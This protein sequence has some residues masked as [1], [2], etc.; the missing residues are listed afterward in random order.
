[1]NDQINSEQYWESRFATQDW[2]QNC[3]QQQTNYF[4]EQFLEN[5]PTSVFDIMKVQASLCDWGCAE[6]QATYAIKN[7]FPNLNVTGIDIS[8]SAIHTAKNLYDNCAF[9]AIDLFNTKKGYDV[10]FTSN[11]LE[12]FENPF[13]VI[14]KLLKHTKKMLIILVPFQEYDR[15]DEH[16]YTFDYKNVPQQI[17]NFQLGCYKTFDCKAVN[18][19]Y[20]WTGYQLLLIYFESKFYS[21]AN[22]SMELLSYGDQ[23]NI[24][25]TKLLMEALGNISEIKKELNLKDAQLIE[26][27]NQIIQKDNQIFDLDNKVLIANER[28][29]NLLNSRSWKLTKPLRLIGYLS[30]KLNFKNN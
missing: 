1:M 11:V 19:A 24:N 28:L 17:E 16:F 27:N 9:E 4:A 18:G 13:E 7:A 20:Y 29:N 14:R 25:N 6:G 22:L 26:I 23:D 21:L 15:I 30:R 2:Q 10:I 3:G 5:L 12:H 8:E